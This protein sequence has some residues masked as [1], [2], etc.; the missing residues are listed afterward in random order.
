MP[1]IGL[2]SPVFV[3]LST[4][5]FVPSQLKLLTH[6]V[7]ISHPTPDLSS[8][9]SYRSGADTDSYSYPILNSTLTSSLLSFRIMLVNR[10]PD[11]LLIEWNGWVAG[12]LVRHFVTF[13]QDGTHL[14]RVNVCEV[15]VVPYPI[16][17]G[18]TCFHVSVCLLI[19]H[20]S[21]GTFTPRLR[22]RFGR[23]LK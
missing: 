4:F 3:R 17:R 1:G 23:Q 22:P 18:V 11:M 12:C 10:K 21:F 14:R 6:L 13:N 20:C 8:I 9:E 2:V 15:P 19:T 7:P 16:R 5:F